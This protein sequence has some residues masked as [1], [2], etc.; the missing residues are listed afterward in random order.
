MQNLTHSP[1]ITETLA[2]EY[3]LNGCRANPTRQTIYTMQAN[4][5]VIVRA[6]SFTLLADGTHEAALRNESNVVIALANVDQF[7]I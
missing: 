7:D 1:E 2:T 5:S 4:G 3:I 6:V